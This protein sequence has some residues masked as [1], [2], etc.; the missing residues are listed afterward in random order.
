MK[1]ARRGK[2]ILAVE[3]GDVTVKGFWLRINSREFFLSYADFPLFRNATRSELSDV[4]VPWPEHVRW[5]TLDIDLEF[6]SIE[7]PSRYPLI[8]RTHPRYSR[9]SEPAPTRRPVKRTK[10]R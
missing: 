1:S 4:A 3:L 7:H 10:R 2:R 8:D 5:E 6:E 9:V